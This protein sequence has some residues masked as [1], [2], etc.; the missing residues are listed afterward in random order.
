MTGRLEARIQKQIRKRA[1]KR[2]D[3]L[4]QERQFAQKTQ[5][6]LDALQEV[7]GLHR[8]ELESIAE[9]VRLA[10]VILILAGFV[11]II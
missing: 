4:R 6:T 3:I 11:Y 1:F 5:H 10:G 7:T 2:A 9:E 8:P